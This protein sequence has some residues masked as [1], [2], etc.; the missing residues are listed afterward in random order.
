[1]S[2]FTIRRQALTEDIATEIVPPVA[3]KAVEVIN[4][5]GGALR[6]YSTPGDEAT[7]LEI[8]DDYYRVFEFNYPGLTAAQVAFHLKAAVA[9]TAILVWK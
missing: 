4:V 1:M 7:Y 3:C 8:A 9:G 5:T 2:A 6:V